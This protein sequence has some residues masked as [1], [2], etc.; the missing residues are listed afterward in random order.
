MGAWYDDLSSEDLRKWMLEQKI[1]WIATSPLSGQGHV[2]VSP[3][4]VSYTIR[5][6]GMLL[7][8]HYRTSIVQPG[9]EQCVLV[10]G[11]DWLWQ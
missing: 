8:A 9:R 11:H 3:K 10:H 4:G 1:F 5:Y 6:L 7:K 2:N